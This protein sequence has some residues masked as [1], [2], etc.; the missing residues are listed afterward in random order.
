[1]RALSIVQAT[2]ADVV[3][4]VGPGIYGGCVLL[5]ATTTDTMIKV[6]DCATVAAV[7]ATNMIDVVAADASIEGNGTSKA[8]SIV[9]P[10]KF[11]TGLVFVIS[12]TGGLGAIWYK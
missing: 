11:T 1:M 2:D 3:V 12:G 9:E 6:Y 5:C 4:K 10:I 8:S 7:A